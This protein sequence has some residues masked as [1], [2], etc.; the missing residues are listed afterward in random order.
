MKKLAN[1]F[2]LKNTDTFLLTGN[3]I[4]LLKIAKQKD[5]KANL[6]SFLDE[7]LHILHIDKMGG[8]SGT[9]LIQTFNWDFCKGVGYDILNTPSQTGVLG[10]LALKMPCFKRTLHPIYSFAVAGKRSFVALK[11]K[12]LLMKH[13][14]LQG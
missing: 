5:K 11:T 6:N 9:L 14:L 12:V 3:F 10:K 2:G 1:S 13:L 4:R 8:G 7:L